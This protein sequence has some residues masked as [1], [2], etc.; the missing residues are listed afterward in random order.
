[1]AIKFDPMFAIKPDGTFELLEVSLVNCPDD[2]PHR[3]LDSE[4]ERLV[5]FIREGGRFIPINPDS[6]KS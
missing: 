5:T 3:I 4:G 2:D 6:E 1:M